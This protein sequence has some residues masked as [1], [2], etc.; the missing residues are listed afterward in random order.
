MQPRRSHLLLDFISQ[1]FLRILQFG[2]TVMHF[3]DAFVYAHHQ[4]RRNIENPGNFG[5]KMKGRI[6][7]MTPS[8]LLMPMRIRRHV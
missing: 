8:L 4:H 6:R 2:I 1:V 7:F 3:I 5:D